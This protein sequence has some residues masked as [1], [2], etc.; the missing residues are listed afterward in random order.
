MQDK[1]KITVS[2]SAIKQI[3][4]LKKQNNNKK[5]MLR[6]SVSSG[7]C[8]GFQYH[9]D[10][11][12]KIKKDDLK[13]YVEK[14]IFAIVDKTSYGFLEESQI[15]F[16]NELGGAYFKMTNPNASSSCGCGSSFAV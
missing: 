9:F 8:S 14:E 12:D 13:I 1:A 15:D 11:A 7:G 2:K 3:D 4:K 5:I 10:F 16:V 6:I